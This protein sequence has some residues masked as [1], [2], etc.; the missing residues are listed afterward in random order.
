MPL[1]VTI[2]C[3][4]AGSGKTSRMVEACCKAIDRDGFGSGA[5]TLVP[6]RM[7][8][9]DFKRRVVARRGGAA[10]LAPNVMTFESLARD[11]L[12][13]NRAAVRRTADTGRFAALREAIDAALDAGDIAVYRDVADLP[14]FARSVERVIGELKR[15]EI[16]PDRFERS[17]ARTGSDRDRELAAIY[18][19]YQSLLMERNLYDD[20]GVY[21]QAGDVAEAGPFAPCRGLRTVLVDGFTDFS[22]PQRRLLRLLGRDL[23]RL[24]IALTHEDDPD[25]ARL[26][27]ASHR[28]LGA[29]RDTFEPCAECRVESLP[30]RDE[31]G[32]LSHIERHLMRLSA[33]RFD[34][35]VDDALSIVETA[36]PAYLVRE[37]LRR[38][39]AWATSGDFRQDEIAVVFRNVAP[40]RDDLR[41]WADRFGLRLDLRA[42]MPF[43][44][45][46]LGRLAVELSRIG[47]DGYP[48]DRLLRLARSTYL[49]PWIAGLL[50]EGLTLRR[51]AGLCRQAG[52]TEGRE[53]IL[54]ALD[55]RAEQASTRADRI[56]PES[57]ASP[58]EARA[59]LATE[60]RQCREAR[61]V[62][63]ALFA[64]L[65]PIAE[66]RAT[67]DARL[68]A[69]EA[70]LDRIE[71]R[72]D[73]DDPRLLRRDLE[74]A[75]ALRA[76]RADLRQVLHDAGPMDAT[77]FAELVDEA[78]ARTQCPAP[79][80]GTGGVAVLSAHQAR[81]LHWPAVVLV[82]L[83][84]GEFPM[85][86]EEN[87]FFGDDRRD[88]FARRGVELPR[89]RDNA[90]DERALFYHA[91]TRAR[92]R[93][94]LA[95]A[96]ADAAGKPNLESPYLRAVRDLF[97]GDKE[98]ERRLPVEHVPVSDIFPPLERVAAE[99]ELRQSGLDALLH[100]G[101][102]VDK[103]RKRSIA[104][105]LAA[106][107]RRRP[108]VYATAFHAARVEDIRW[109]TDE[110]ESHD[111][112]IGDEAVCA[113]LGARF[114]D[115]ARWSPT[116]LERYAGCGLAF[117]FQDLLGLEDEEN[118]EGY[119][120]RQQGSVLHNVL[121]RFFAERVEAG[122]ARLSTNDADA[123]RVRI[124]ELALEELT[125]YDAALALHGEAI[126]GALHR[127]TVRMCEAFVDGEV[128]LKQKEKVALVPTH[129]EFTFGQSDD[130]GGP[131]IERPL[132][133]ET[134][135]IRVQ[136]R[137]RIDRIDTAATDE[138]L[139]IDV[140]DYKRSPTSVKRGVENGTHLQLPVY[141]MAAQRLLFADRETVPG[142][143]MLRDLRH[144]GKAPKTKLDAETLDLVEEN[145]VH[146]VAFIRAGHFPPPAESCSNAYCPFKT[147]CRCHDDRIARKEQAD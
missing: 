68:A 144:P 25:R 120:A 145:I 53:A 83:S 92:R 78:V 128:A 100:G 19:R 52:V 80:E 7:L 33:P 112:V 93:L 47:V 134:D 35:P 64:A 143:G 113:V 109:S 126:A 81:G 22:P 42:A 101:E 38:V 84:E 107:A 13:Q 56:D 133:I 58:E 30:P 82:G 135:E 9:D 77:R 137:G 124:R 89:S 36:T 5:L 122:G 8:V 138:G 98:D 41:R 142:E 26:F 2:L 73:M 43:G 17:A 55:R 103:N 67:A 118:L 104:S 48:V 117:F 129:F 31:T 108:A 49:E 12:L 4:P 87:V 123:A 69:L 119:D 24:T 105:A 50:P 127:E 139:R 18:R 115:S 66:P 34:G 136:L 45:T 54:G 16:P 146:D 99:T 37:V 51:I 140:I 79:R 114:G 91:V 132:T 14:G 40:W 110:F 39:R 10:I 63:D 96:S 106:L 60:A 20:Q 44:H 102:R 97:E 131:A 116:R 85:R 75:P 57:E 88:G 147:I 72:D 90:A 76:V 141:M 59:A 23:E 3:G 15:A 1:N 11:I 74:A 32:P 21:W 125:R 130:E 94:V 111:G 62:L 70:V 29:L 28:T 65:D 121:Q 61:T 46:G 71:L 6:N 95:W 86:S 27:A